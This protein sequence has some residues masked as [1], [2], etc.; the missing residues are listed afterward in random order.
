MPK[1]A[2]WASL[3]RHLLV[4]IILQALRTRNLEPGS[5]HLL[6]LVCK[7]WR[8]ALLELAA[9]LDVASVCVNSSDGLSH[10]CR[11]LPSVNKLRIRKDAVLYSLYLNPL[12]ACSRLSSIRLHND[13][14]LSGRP[15]IDLSLLPSRLRYLDIECFELMRT[16][17]LAFT[18]EFTRLDFYWWHTPGDD[19]FSLLHSLPNLQVRVILWLSLASIQ[20][21]ERHFIHRSVT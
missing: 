16:G 7:E 9:E 1:Q 8:E 10:V 19:F 20:E 17:S 6:Q 13:T 4:S 15:A 11:M 18:T 3:P 12:A 14:P 5:F 21:L 2:G